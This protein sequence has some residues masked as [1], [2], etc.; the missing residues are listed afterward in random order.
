MADPRPITLYLVE[1]LCGGGWFLQA[2][3]PFLVEPSDGRPPFCQFAEPDCETAHAVELMS[4]PDGSP[5]ARR[6]R[7]CPFG[8]AEVRITMEPVA[9]AAAPARVPP[10]PV[11]PPDDGT[12]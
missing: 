9:T 3:C 10:D 11:S 2:I 6:Q 1:R 8:D 7:N 5:L 12:A 4:D